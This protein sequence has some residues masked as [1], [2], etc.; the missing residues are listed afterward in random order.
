[1]P[2]GPLAILPLPGNVSSIVWTEP[3]AAAAR[4][5]ALPD[6]GFLAALAPQFGDFLG[7][8][9][10][11]GARFDYP[12]SLS[13][14]HCFVGP[15]VALLGDAAHAVHPVAGQ[16]LN[17]G[18]KDVG[19][20]TEVLVLA[21]RR[22]EDL[23]RPDVLDRYQRWRRF[24]VA[25][26]AL[27]TDAVVRLFS[28]DVGPLRLVRDLGLGMIQR[29]APLRRGLIREAAGLTGEVPRLNRGLPV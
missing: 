21:A 28:N 25:S 15:R 6:D 8:L 24:D 3:S 1:M 7:P 19:A 2:S 17:A 22:G 11:A 27:S 14:A 4:I 29:L 5:A 18:L 23:G 9:S 20:L 13:M 10:L 12:L 16:G 26:L